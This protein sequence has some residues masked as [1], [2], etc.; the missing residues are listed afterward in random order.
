MSSEVRAGLAKVFAELFLLD[1]HASTY[2]NYVYRSDFGER[3]KPLL[4]RGKCVEV[5]V[6]VVDEVTVESA[7]G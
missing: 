7:V 1:R 3:I 6:R 2:R 4:P 5:S